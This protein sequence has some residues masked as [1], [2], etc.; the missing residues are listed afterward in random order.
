MESLKV[1]GYSIEAVEMLILPMGMTAYE[2]LGSMGTDT[3]LACL[4]KRPHSISEYFKQLFAQV[5][6]SV[7][8]D[9]GHKIGL[10]EIVAFDTSLR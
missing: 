5:L 7:C 1:F 8:G 2:P 4:S 9:F 3:P 10:V 6:P